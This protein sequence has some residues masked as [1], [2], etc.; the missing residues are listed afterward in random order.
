[1]VTMAETGATRTL[2]WIAHIHSHTFIAITTWCEAPALLLFFSAYWV[3]SCFCNPPN[4][5]MGLQD[6]YLC[7]PQGSDH[8]TVTWKVCEGSLQHID[9]R[10]EQKENAFSLGKSLLIGEEVGS[11]SLI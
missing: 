7:L 4:S 10:E 11:D 5:D 2:T 9:V 8:L 6:V 3:F 1:M